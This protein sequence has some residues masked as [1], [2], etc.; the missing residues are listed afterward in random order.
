MSLVQGA[1]ESR[2]MFCTRVR[3]FLRANDHHGRG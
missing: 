3:N 1:S 2:K